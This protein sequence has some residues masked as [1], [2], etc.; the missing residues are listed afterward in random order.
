MGSTSQ[1]IDYAT[2]SDQKEFLICTEI[3]VFYELERRNPDKQFHAVSVKQTCGNMKKNTLE[4]VLQ[5]LSGEQREVVVEKEYEP[6]ARKAL[7]QMLY[8]MTA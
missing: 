4:G 6:L 2:E 8:Y 7:E 1:I 5:A 3:G